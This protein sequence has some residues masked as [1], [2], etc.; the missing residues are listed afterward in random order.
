MCV[1]SSEQRDG[2]NIYQILIWSDNEHGHSIY[3]T[4]VIC[5]DLR[6]WREYNQICERQK[7]DREII[8]T[9]EII[10]FSNF[11][12][13]TNRI[14]VISLL[15]EKI[16]EVVQHFSFKTT[17]QL[18]FHKLKFRKSLIK[19]YNTFIFSWIIIWIK[20]KLNSSNAKL[21]YYLSNLTS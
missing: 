2:L 14:A 5:Y 3:E 6:V 21:H 8:H 9:L 17:W 13:A 20:Y 18:L 12:T 4:L 11:F 15:L 7:T 16:Q 10:W 1:C 19:N